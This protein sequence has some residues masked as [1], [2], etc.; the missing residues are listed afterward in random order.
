MAQENLTVTMARGYQKALATNSSDSSFTSKVPTLT[1]PANDGVLHLG[2]AKGGPYGGTIPQWMLCLPYGLGAD[3][4]AFSI[5]AI[6]WRRIV[7]RTSS[8]K[9]LWIPTTLCEL[10]A[11]ISGA[12]GVAGAPVLNTERFADTLTIVAEPTLTADVTSGSVIVFSQANDTPAW[13]A[14][15]L[16]GCEK[17]E[18]T[19]DQT[20]NT[21]TMN[22]LVGFF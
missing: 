8:E 22:A 1:E 12:V 18:F 7:G 17:V 19:F 9:T 13:F 11:T 16:R 20:T 4:D 3:N 2:G 15:E 21:P 6:G 14:V 5:R 10:S